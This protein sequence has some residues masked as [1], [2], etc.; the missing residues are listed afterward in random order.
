MRVGVY[1]ILAK[2]GRALERAQVA[3][4]MRHGLLPYQP[5][6]FGLGLGR[7]ADRDAEGTHRKWEL[8]EPRLPT[9]P[10]SALD[11]GCNIGYFSFKLAQHGADHVLGIDVERGPLVIA[12]KLKVLGRVDN[13]GFLTRSIDERNVDLLGEYDV[14]LFLSVFHHLVYRHGMAAARAILTRLIG[15]AR[16]SFF[17]ETGQGDQGFGKFAGAMPRMS[18]DEVPDFVVGLL[19][20]CGAARVDLLGESAL[21]SGASRFLFLASTERA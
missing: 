3:V 6:P 17:F 21:K 16:H 8:I 20:E 7:R 18:R 4:M 1:S 11:L 14:I 15:K 10:Y 19:R 2:M 5:D 13:V 9:A 12:E